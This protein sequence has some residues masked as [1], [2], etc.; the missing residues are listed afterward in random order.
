[1]VT[2][3]TDSVWGA[4]TD[5]PRAAF[6][7]EAGT[8]AHEN[9]LSVDPPEGL[10]EEPPVVGEVPVAAV[11]VGAEVVELEH[12]ARATGI[13]RRTRARST[14]GGRPGACMAQS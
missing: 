12:A 3:P 8:S 4:P 7:S 14:D 5:V 9:A 2:V 11:V 13:P 1:M 6:T 10:P